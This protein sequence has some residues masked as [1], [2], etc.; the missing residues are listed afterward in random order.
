MPIQTFGASIFPADTG[1]KL[2]EGLTTVLS[3]NMPIII[4][5]LGFTLGVGLAFRLLKK[6]S[7]VKA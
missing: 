5:L 4:T 3:D 2:I 1:T 7:K 6:F